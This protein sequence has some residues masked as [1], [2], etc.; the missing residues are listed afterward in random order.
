MSQIKIFKNK[1]SKTRIKIFLTFCF[2]TLPLFISEV[3]AQPDPPQPGNNEIPFEGLGILAALGI[4]YAVT[5]L[6]KK[7]KQK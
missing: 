1:M 2:L 7:S 6:R 4:T 3:L 5:K